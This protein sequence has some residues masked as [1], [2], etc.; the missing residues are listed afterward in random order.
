[1][2]KAAAACFALWLSASPGT[3]AGLDVQAVNEAQFEAGKAAS[4]AKEPLLLKA[5]VL[6]SRA[7]FSPG[8]ID[9]KPGANFSKALSAFAR[10]RGLQATD[11]LNEEVWRELAKVSTEPP[12]T[13]YTIA[14][15]DVRGPFAAKIPARLEDMKDLPALSFVS[16]RELLAE[17]FHM[18]EALLSALNPG[19]KLDSAGERIVVVNLAQ[20]LAQAKLEKPARIE[21]NKTDQTLQAFGRD[22]K[23]LAFY[24]VTAG[25]SEK[26]APSERLKVTVIKKNPTYRYNPEYGF[27]GVRTR[28]PFTVKP[29]PN[30]PVG[31][32]WIGLSGEG[33]GLHGTPEPAKVSKSESHGCIRLTNWDALELASAITKGTPVDFVGDEQE[34][35]TARAQARGS[36]GRQPR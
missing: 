1:M 16:P 28:K 32:V 21:V 31:A 8:E 2:R 10:D 26:P 29:G 33:Y 6:L 34:R 4:P 9:G 5:Q 24:P 19:K 7:R 27:K 36:R 35:R 23:L 17:K 25:S 18:S 22:G 3:T 11:K 13:E 30:N 12:L 15:A 14:E 20:N